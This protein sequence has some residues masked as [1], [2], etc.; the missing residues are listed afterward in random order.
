MLISEHE[1]SYVFV[2][3]GENHST[4]KCH[5]WLTTLNVWEC[6][7]RTLQGLIMIFISSMQHISVVR[8]HDLIVILTVFLNGYL[9][10]KI[11]TFS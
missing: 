3:L 6:C 8:C 1:R 11:F 9:T 2:P 7:T 5:L 10:V 4:F